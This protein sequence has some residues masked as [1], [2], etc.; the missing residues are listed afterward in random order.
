MNNPYETPPTSL[1]PTLRPP[2]K[3]WLRFLL[4]LLSGAGLIYLGVTLGGAIALGAAC[5][6]IGLIFL[7][8]LCIPKSP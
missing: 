2:D 1:E 8:S 3:G 6:V 5:C 4:T 7:L